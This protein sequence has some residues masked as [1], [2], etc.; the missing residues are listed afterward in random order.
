MSRIYEKGLAEWNRWHSYK[1]YLPE[2]NVWVRKA[3]CLIAEHVMGYSWYPVNPKKDFC[4]YTFH[5]FLTAEKP[6]ERYVLEP[7][8]HVPNYSKNL[9]DALKVAR[10][11]GIVTIPVLE[12]DCAM[13]KHI[14]DTALYQAEQRLRGEGNSPQ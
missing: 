10:K 9:Y 2:R 4:G 11:L 7:D 12:T 6:D 1:E 14:A 8:T 13:A 3:D 5:V